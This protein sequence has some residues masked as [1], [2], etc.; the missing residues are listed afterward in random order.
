MAFRPCLLHRW[1][2][3]ARQGQ[4]F[5]ASD[6]SDVRKDVRRNL[7]WL[8]ST[9]LALTWRAAQDAPLEPF[10]DAVRQSV[11]CFGVPGYSGLAR[12]MVPADAMASEIGACI[13]R[14]EPRL[15]P[16]PERL[17]VVPESADRDS[18]QHFN[19]LTF[20]IRGYLRADPLERFEVRT[21]LNF[22]SGQ[23]QVDG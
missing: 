11:L 20:L 8:F 21:V 16:A 18:H 9:E 7:E 23:A 14:F 4:P 19:S 17:E 13:R 2:L 6:W 5:A 3:L 22:E 10:P 12:S 1:D 15:D